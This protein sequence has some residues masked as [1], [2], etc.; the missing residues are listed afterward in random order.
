MALVPRWKVPIRVRAAW[1]IGLAAYSGF[2]AVM[3]YLDR[4]LKPTTATWLHND[5]FIIAIVVTLSLL[6]LIDYA[7]RAMWRVQASRVETNKVGVRDQL[8][9]ILVTVAMLHKVAVD[10]LETI[11]CSLFLVRGRG[12]RRPKI[13][14][15][16]HRMRIIDNLPE[17]AAVFTKNKGVV[18]YCWQNEKWWHVDL[19]PVNREFDGMTL[20]EIKD[21]WPLITV[22]QHMNFTPEE[23]VSL[24]GKYRE[25]LAVPVMI[26]HK[27]EGCIALDRRW[28]KD[29]P[30]DR[31]LFNNEQTKRILGSASN[32]LLPLLRARS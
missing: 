15:R 1:S 10:D 8:S 9:T 24:T 19:D 18:G 20:D 4:R 23:F 14:Y 26:D 6:T 31:P 32:T 13:L 29:D 2:V 17:S 27:F 11:G 28:N 22:D 21:L 12:V 5:R 7:R 3:V 30:Q 25:V 16:V